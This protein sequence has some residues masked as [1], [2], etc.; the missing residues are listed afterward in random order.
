MLQR[1]TRQK[2]KATTT[3]GTTFEVV[4]IAEEKGEVKTIEEPIEEETEPA[5]LEFPQPV[6]ET[7]EGAEPPSDSP[8]HPEK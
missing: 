8:S 3:K 5:A 1:S 4:E 7:G 6:L 2:K